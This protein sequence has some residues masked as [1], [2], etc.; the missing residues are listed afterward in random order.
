VRARLLLAED[1][2]VNQKVAVKMLE[3]L[4]YR[5]DVAANGLEAVEAL[6]RVPYSAV[7]MDCHM[8]E[9]DGYEAT[10]EIRRREGERGGRTPIIALTAGAMKGDRD[11]ALD[12]GMDDY[13]PKPVKREQL[14]T[15]LQRWVS[16]EGVTSPTGTEGSS[17]HNELEESLDHTVIA[18]LR[19]LGDSDLLSELTQMFVEEVPEQLGAL[20][21]AIENGDVQTVR[22]IG[23]TLKGSSGNMGARQMSRL[24]HDLEHAGE[25]NDLPAAARLLGAI[26][27]EFD[28]VRTQLTALVG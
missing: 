16:R 2:A 6:Q 15:M 20:R 8:P 17:P 23:H 22:R 7:L 13:L 4:G 27:E 21:E 19:E 12:A 1:N 28:N 9:M 24:C 25:A 26:E 11:R 3:S 14:E 10:A 18:N 5:V